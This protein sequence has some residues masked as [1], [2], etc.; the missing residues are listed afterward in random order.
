[1]KPTQVGLLCCI[2]GNPFRPVTIEPAW[3]NW[4][5]SSIP[6]IAQRV[7]DDCRFEDLPILAGALEEAGCHNAEI[8]AHCRGPGP[9]VRGCWVVDLLLGREE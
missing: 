8:L 5:D 2:S 7:Y 9:H 3:L 6:K 4:N 1:M